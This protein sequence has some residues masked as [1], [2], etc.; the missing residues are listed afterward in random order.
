MGEGWWRLVCTRCEFRG[1]AADESLA[2]RLAAV[3]A[4]AAGHDVEVLP[5]DA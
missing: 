1:R 2:E 5:P 4:D 3:H